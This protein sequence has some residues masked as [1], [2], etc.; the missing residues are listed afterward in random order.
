MSEGGSK[1]TGARETPGPQEAAGEDH[2][3]HEL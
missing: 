1:A 2:C 3:P